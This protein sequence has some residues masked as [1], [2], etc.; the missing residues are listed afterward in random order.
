MSSLSIITSAICKVIRGQ[1]YYSDT[2]TLQADHPL[3]VPP[4]AVRFTPWCFTDTSH[5][6]K[7]C[8]Q[9]SVF[10]CYWHG[11]LPC[12]L[13]ALLFVG[14]VSLGFFPPWKP[15]CLSWR[16]SFCLDGFLL[17]IIICWDGI[18]EHPVST[19]ASPFGFH[20]EEKQVWRHRRN[21]EIWYNKIRGL[22]LWL[23][24]LQHNGF[25]IEVLVLIWYC[26]NM[27]EYF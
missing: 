12:S 27:N 24:E 20:M 18:T 23:L 3:T 25:Y 10:D 5:T 6:T 9:Q 2:H 1:F 26:L 7:P 22:D 14:N 15:L 4:P 13:L 21:Y 8:C 17:S 19:L 16:L 11:K